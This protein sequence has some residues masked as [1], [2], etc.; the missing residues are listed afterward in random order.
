[1]KGEHRKKQKKVC[2][3]TATMTLERVSGNSVVWSNR[4]HARQAVAGL[5]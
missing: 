5:L 3:I 1:M 2:S 4:E